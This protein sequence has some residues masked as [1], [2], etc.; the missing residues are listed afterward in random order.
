M[1]LQPG[2]ILSQIDIV[3]LAK[4]KGYF[5]SIRPFP[6]PALVI[7]HG[8]ETCADL[9]TEETKSIFKSDERSFST[10]F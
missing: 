6:G 10:K 9:E 7:L 8:A 3:N 4:Q 2:L 5:V 1:E